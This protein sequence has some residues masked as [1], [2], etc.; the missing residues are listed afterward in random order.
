[1]HRE[2]KLS[3]PRTQQDVPGTVGAPTTRSVAERTN[4]EATAPPSYGNVANRY[5]YSPAGHRPESRS[6]FGYIY[7][8]KTGSLD[9]A[10]REFS[11]A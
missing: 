2:S 1:M 4:H 8:L 3:C 5:N 11:F 7:L 9:N 10:I 6:S